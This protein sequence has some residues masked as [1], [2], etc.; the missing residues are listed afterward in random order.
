MTLYL[1]FIHVTQNK[2]LGMETKKSLIFHI[3]SLWNLI[4]S[5]NVKIDFAVNT[6]N[7]FIAISTSSYKKS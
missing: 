1:C 6:S 3:M 2:F 7:L 5:D 4:F